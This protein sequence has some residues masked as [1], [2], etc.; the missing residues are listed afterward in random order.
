[1]FDLE[2]GFYP[3]SGSNVEW[4]HL[5]FVSDSSIATF[6]L[7]RFYKIKYNT[8]I[9]VAIAFPDVSINRILVHKRDIGSGYSILPG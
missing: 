2:R 1:M 3:F 9:T 8:L 7:K 5:K 4:N 6:I